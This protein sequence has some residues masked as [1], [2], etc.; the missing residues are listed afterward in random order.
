VAH[1]N[2]PDHGPARGPLTRYFLLIGGALALFLV[3]FLVA[4]ALSVAVLDD[5]TPWLGGGDAFDGAIG[6]A[7]LIADVVLPVPSSLIMIAYGA[8]FGI[9]GG[10]S[11]S[12]VG[13]LGAAMAGYAIGR[14]AGPPLLRSVC[15]EA[16]HARA[17]RFVRRWGALAV[18]ASR[19]VPLLAE[20]VAIAA[21]ASS[22]G[23]TRTLIWAAV[24]S[25]PGAVLYAVAGSAGASAPSGLLVFG[26]VLVVATV[27]WMGGRRIEKV[28]RR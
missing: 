28:E 26:L 4:E 13:S 10:A 8:L 25:V 14:C 22:L 11:V 17:D 18:A 20:T 16:E 19:P 23:V 6:T 24:G 7:L 21:G 12:L 1:Q 2:G 9:V 15:S 3:I 5:P 27:L